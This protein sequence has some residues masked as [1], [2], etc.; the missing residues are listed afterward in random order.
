[1]SRKIATAALTALLI[2]AGG[3]ATFRTDPAT[4]ATTSDKFN[5]VWDAS[6]EVLRGENFVIDRADRRSGVITTEP[7]LGRHWFEFW[8]ADA[9]TRRDVTEGS[10]QTIYRRAVVHVLPAKAGGTDPDYV[11]N[12]AVETSRS[13]LPTVRVT[14]TSEAYELFYIP[15]K[16]LG[17]REAAL[18]EIDP[19]VRPTDRPVKLGPD[20]ILARKLGGQIEALA[21][22]KLSLT[23]AGQ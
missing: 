3:C 7:M 9:A 8:R 12:V 17:G 5:A 2:S 13:D 10:V 21:S 18:P 14:N 16:M 11:A 23:P 4:P 15:Q 6:L 1:M 22:R 19:D 20:E